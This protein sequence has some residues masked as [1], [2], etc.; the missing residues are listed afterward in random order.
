MLCPESFQSLPEGDCSYIRQEG[1]DECWGYHEGTFA[2][3]SQLRQGLSVPVQ[4][5]TCP[6]T[7]PD[8]G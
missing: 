5:Q 2:L 3:S 6:E 8:S 4:V 1:P 7:L